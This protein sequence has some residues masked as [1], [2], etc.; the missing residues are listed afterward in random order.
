MTSTF[1]SCLRKSLFMARTTRNRTK[2]TMMK[3]I[4]TVVNYAIHPEVLGNTVGVLSPDLVGPLCDTIEA[5]AG[6]RLCS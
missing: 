6:G 5:Q 1:S 2:A 3:L 4:A